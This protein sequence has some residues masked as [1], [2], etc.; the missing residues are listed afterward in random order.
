M[1]DEQTIPD[2]WTLESETTNYQHRMDREYT[3]ITYTGPDGTTVRINTVQEYG[4]LDG[5]GY[6]VQTDDPSSGTL[7]L[8]DSLDEAKDV[9]RSYMESAPE[10]ATP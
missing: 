8:T 7:A 6:Q 4:K 5:W 9:A 2:G 1:A 10:V 3:R